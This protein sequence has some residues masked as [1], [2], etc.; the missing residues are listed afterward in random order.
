M[1]SS[2]WDKSK[3]RDTV[4]S[5]LDHLQAIAT[6]LELSVLRGAIP[7]YGTETYPQAGWYYRTFLTAIQDIL[8]TITGQLCPTN[9]T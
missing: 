2:K 7:L 8:D 1:T 3:F 9:K 6:S 5:P 4:E